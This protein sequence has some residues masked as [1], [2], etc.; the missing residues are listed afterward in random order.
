MI[1]VNICWYIVS[2]TKEELEYYL[3]K[4]P[5]YKDCYYVI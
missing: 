1:K 3:F 4:F 2:L 5:E